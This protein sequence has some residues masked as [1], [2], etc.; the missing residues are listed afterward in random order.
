MTTAVTVPRRQLPIGTFALLGLVVLAFV[1]AMIRYAGG[2]GAASN[3]NDNYAWGLW[4]SVDLLV[5]V[6]LAASAFTTATAVY[7]LGQER[8][9]PILRPAILT[10][11]LGYLMVI[12]A[13]LVDLGRP[14]RIWYLIIF[15]NHH[16]VMFEVGL[17]VMTYTLV[18]ALEFSPMLFERFG[19]R[20]PL[21]LI[22]SLT[23]PLVIAGTV[24][25]TLHQSSL[26][27]LYLIIPD[28]LDV[29]WHSPLLPLF[30]FLSAVA[31]GPSMVILESSISSRVFKR[32]LELDLL[33]SLAK[34]I[35]FVLALYLALKIA[36]LGIA[37]ELGEAF[38]GSRNSALFLLEMVGGVILPMVLFALP[39]IRRN[40]GTLLLAA[41][42]VVGG[43]VLNRIDVGLL[44]FSRPADAAT[45]V[46]SWMEFFITI[47][48]VAAGLIAFGL[49]ARHLPLFSYA[50]KTGE[51][52]AV[53]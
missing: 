9:R 24:L 27:S 44:G 46:P 14:E 29:L 28:Q 22:T 12:L 48:I 50:S 2:L 34:A 49:V 13:L 52:S 39:A 42:L 8:Y 33:A 51:E 31:V 36:D 41:S 53:H 17:C 16:S 11:F 18:L 19:L 35:P 4:I 10:G 43:V 15:W 6:A 40:S 21:R 32:G 3:L 1:I 25:S 7:I 37:G 45:Y 5:G 38:N 30:F 26:G 23:L 47:G 20:R